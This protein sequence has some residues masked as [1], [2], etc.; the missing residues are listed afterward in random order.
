MA[1]G[2]SSAL[3]PG[4]H[5]V[6]GLS[7]PLSIITSFTKCSDIYNSHPVTLFFLKIFWVI[8]KYLLF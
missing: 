1:P 8:L 3:R 5:G 2:L 6:T 7:L 4:T